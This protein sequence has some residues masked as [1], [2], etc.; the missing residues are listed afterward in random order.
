MVI[1]KNILKEKGKKKITRSHNC[2]TQKNWHWN[3]YLKIDTIATQTSV[4]N[5]DSMI[6]T[7]YIYINKNFVGTLLG[8][9]K[10]SD[11]YLLTH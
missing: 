2:P 4:L 10:F 11:I 5:K 6:H 8:T 9:K 1:P 3:F 7:V